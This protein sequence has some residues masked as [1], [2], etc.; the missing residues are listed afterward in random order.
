M[1]FVDVGVQ[2]SNFTFVFS[3]G[4]VIQS[5]WCGMCN[6]YMGCQGGFDKGGPIICELVCYFIARYASKCSY[7]LDN[8]FVRRPFYLVCY[9]INESFV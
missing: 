3:S 8:S 5:I 6:V 1:F 7:F 2:V 4:D 9:G